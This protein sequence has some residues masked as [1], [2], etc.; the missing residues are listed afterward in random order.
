MTT[1]AAQRPRTRGPSSNSKVSVER[2]LMELVRALLLTIEEKGGAEGSAASRL[3][4]AL[5][6]AGFALRTPAAKAEPRGF[7]EGP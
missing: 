4:G 7:G 6:A 5:D 3:I 1:N 2:A